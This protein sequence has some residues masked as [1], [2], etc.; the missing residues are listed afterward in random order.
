[1][2]SS[3]LS[4]LSWH[5]SIFILHLS[6][7]QRLTSLL[8]IVDSFQVPILIQSLILFS[9]IPALFH[10][11]SVYH[12]F[13]HTGVTFVEI[14]RFFMRSVCTHKNEKK[15]AKFVHTL[16]VSDWEKV[17][18]YC[19][20]SSTSCLSYN[21][22]CAIVFHCH[23]EHQEGLDLLNVWIHNLCRNTAFSS[24]FA[25]YWVDFWLE[26]GRIKSQ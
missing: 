17:N 6:Y 16:Y 20:T 8:L 4:G 18:K 15:W 12:R 3:V 2:H 19:V 23:C 7:D 13:E 25:A 26:N 21:S 5:Q 10:Q 11:L 9:P 1:M 22:R 24:L 14:Q